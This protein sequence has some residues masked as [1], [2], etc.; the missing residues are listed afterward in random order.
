MKSNFQD[1]SSIP[2]TFIIIMIG[3]CWVGAFHILL[4]V[5]IYY[6]SLLLSLL[7]FIFIWILDW[8]LQGNYKTPWQKTIIGILMVLLYLSPIIGV[9]IFPTLV[10]EPPSMVD[11]ARE[12]ATKKTLAAMR[13]S[14]NNY[15]KENN[16]YPLTLDTQVHT[17]DTSILPPF[18]PDYIELIPYA[19]TQRK[20]D[21][22][23]YR[24][25]NVVIVTT[26]PGQKIQPEQ[27]TDEG[28]W[29]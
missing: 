2:I 22:L 8:R 20:R 26:R 18:V 10:Y 5:G 17:I 28:G 7:I 6:G 9:C 12:G 27:I 16:I 21:I 4:R 11:K 25:N 13:S 23:H 3:V 29:I 1:A 14:I 15:Y 24:S 19:S